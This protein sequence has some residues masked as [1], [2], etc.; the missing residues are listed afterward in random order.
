MATTFLT[1]WEIIA[2]NTIIWTGVFTPKTKRHSLHLSSS[3][4]YSQYGRLLSIF[5]LSASYVR[6][7]RLKNKSNIFPERP[8]KNWLHWA[9]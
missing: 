4:K 7:L 8:L 5:N 1:S 6:P 9:L 2:H 3:T